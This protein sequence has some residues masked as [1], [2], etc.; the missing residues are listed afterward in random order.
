MNNQ[1]LTIGQVID[2]A[3][4]KEEFVHGITA[5]INAIGAFEECAEEVRD[6]SP[7]VRG[8]SELGW[9]LSLAELC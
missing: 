2:E 5:G 7:V 8:V 1:K 9:F 4:D 6:L 3:M